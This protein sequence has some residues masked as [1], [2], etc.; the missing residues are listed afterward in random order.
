MEAL[1]GE[2]RR[3]DGRDA[4]RVQCGLP[5]QGERAYQL[6]GSHFDNVLIVPAMISRRSFGIRHD[7]KEGCGPQ[8]PRPLF[9]LVAIRL[10]TPS[11]FRSGAPDRPSE[12]SR[13]SRVCRLTHPQTPPWRGASK[14]LSGRR[15]SEERRCKMGCSSLIFGSYMRFRTPSDFRSGAPDRPSGVR[16]GAA[17]AES[18]PAEAGA[19][20]RP[21]RV[22]GLRR[23]GGARWDIAA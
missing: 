18:A 5:R 23:S 11:D 20:A 16:G 10:R 22:V 17:F 19:W 14:A 12:R 7:G 9:Y 15:A 13:R 6:A 8:K 2:R 1:Y 3:R 4:H 21:S